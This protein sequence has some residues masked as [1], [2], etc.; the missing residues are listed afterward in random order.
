MNELKNKLLK[1][2]KI[3]RLFSLQVTQKQV[4]SKYIQVFLCAIATWTPRICSLEN[5][6][7]ILMLSSYREVFS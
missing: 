7:F 5:N 4:R 1:E 6:W 3:L 2:I